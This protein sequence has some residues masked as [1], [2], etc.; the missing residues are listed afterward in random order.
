MFKNY[1]LMLLVSSIVVLQACKKDD[2]ATVCA[3]TANELKINQ[4]QVLGSHNSYRKAMD[5]DIFDFLVS[6]QSLLPGNAQPQELDYAH[7][8]LAEQ[9]NEYG[10][11]SFEIDIYHD[12]TGGRFYNRT[13][14]ALV[15]RP[16]ASNVPSL[17]TPGL[18]VL[19]MPD[20]DFNTHHY[21]F[22]DALQTLKIW[23]ANNHNHLPLFVYIEPKTSDLTD[24]FLHY[25][26]AALPF[27]QGF[28][29]SIDLEIN[30]VFGEDAD[31]VITPDEVRGSFNTLE[32]AVLAG[33]W[34][35]LE[36]AR[37][38]ILFV[39]GHSGYKDNHPS[40]VDR[41]A[42]SFSTPGE[43][44][45][46]FVLLNDPITDLEKIRDYVGL[47]YM[48]RTRTDAGTYEAKSGDYTRSNA[49]FNSG[50]QL[51]STDYYKSDP[52]ADTSAVWTDFKVAFPNGELARVNAYAGGVLG[53]GCFIGE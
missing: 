49:A 9:L 37:G 2:P 19:H 13:G 50:A 46:A 45:C 43:P 34:P 15:S 28:A 3:K 7:A 44:E 40:L 16:E 18:K 32:E 38:K 35:T 53:N 25:W 10:M 52:R 17:Q 4:I 29:D 31:Q 26:T 42:F 21:T 5:R 23:S 27:T 51:I 48:V 30:A 36:E 24:V 39:V 14:N 22:I 33:N 20:I 41:V 1:L 47:G 12:P 8:S 11:R 6:V